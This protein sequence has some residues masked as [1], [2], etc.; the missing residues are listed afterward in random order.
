MPYYYDDPSNPG[1]PRYDETTATSSGRWSRF[2]K[3]SRFLHW[4]PDPNVFTGQRRVVFFTPI[5][6]QMNPGD[7]GLGASLIAAM[8]TD[9][10]GCHVVSFETGPGGFYVPGVQE[11]DAIFGGEVMAQTAA[12]YGYFLSR[13]NDTS[14]WNTDFTCDPD[15]SHAMGWGSSAGAWRTAKTLLARD[16]D[17][18]YHHAGAMCGLSSYTVR[19]SAAL[20]FALLH[21]GQYQLSS[22]VAARKPAVDPSYVVSGTNSTGSIVLNLKTGNSQPIY[23]G[24]KLTI[25]SKVYCVKADFAGG[26]TGQVSIY[27]SLQE[28]ATDGTAISFSWDGIEKYWPYGWC[29]SY[30]FRNGNG[31]VWN[32]H[33]ANAFPMELKLELDC[34]IHLSSSNRRC[35][36]LRVMFFGGDVGAPISSQL[37]GEKSFL[38]NTVPG[39]PNPAYINLHAPHQAYWL[40]HRL[41]SLGNANVQVYAG[42]ATNNPGP[43]DGTDGRPWC[44]GTNAM[45]TPAILKAFL[46]A[47]GF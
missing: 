19:Q 46:Q 43:Y 26:A 2:V 6:A 30:G 18:D 16:G 31:Q 38:L 37:T 1:N 29:G 23:M 42:N 47:G 33:E 10:L 45:F 5:G 9:E 12:A 3:H 4:K 13:Y 20:G 22:F 24:T 41:S 14:I 32:A 35:T 15:P 36:D 11:P 27:P 7:L 8:L 21:Q 28:D 44:K 34:D 25:G 40:A 17:F 39:T